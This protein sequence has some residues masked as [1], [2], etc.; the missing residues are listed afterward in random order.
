MINPKSFQNF[1]QLMLKF[2]SL[3]GSNLYEI[4]KSF[5]AK[6]LDLFPEPDG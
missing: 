3:L 6:I 5:P 4:T 2:Y 1:H